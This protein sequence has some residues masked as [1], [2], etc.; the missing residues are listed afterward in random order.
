M[1]KNPKCENAQNKCEKNDLN[2]S[3]LVST[4]NKK[5]TNFQ[6]KSFESNSAKGFSLEQMDDFSFKKQDNERH[7]SKVN[8]KKTNLSGVNL[9]LF[10]KIEQFQKKHF[11][12]TEPNNNDSND[13]KGDELTVIPESVTLKR[14][15]SGES[16]EEERNEKQKRKKFY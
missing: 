5:K 15:S 2:Q 6:T 13:E 8:L 10:E 4:N 14:V 7:S 3:V 16:L 12:H 1:N 11:K 9:K